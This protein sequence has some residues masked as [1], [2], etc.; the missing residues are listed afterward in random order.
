MI[1]NLFMKK[2]ILTVI[3]IACVVTASVFLLW[4]ALA[5]HNIDG[6]KNEQPDGKGFTVQGVKTGVA[7]SCVSE[8]FRQQG[9]YTCT[10]SQQLMVG[11]ENVLGQAIMLPL[12]IWGSLIRLSN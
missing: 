3:L 11:F 9:A 4:F 10:R 1:N 12:I 2:E 5:L 6:F 8:G 7:Y